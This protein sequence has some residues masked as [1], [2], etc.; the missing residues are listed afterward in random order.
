MNPR[1][2]NANDDADDIHTILKV[3]RPWKQDVLATAS[4]E[5]DGYRQDFVRRARKSR[6]PPP[7]LDADEREQLRCSQPVDKRD[8][9]NDFWGDQTFLRSLSTTQRKK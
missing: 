6:S 3:D 5:E 4:P 2:R 1:K 9:A 8:W 7:Y